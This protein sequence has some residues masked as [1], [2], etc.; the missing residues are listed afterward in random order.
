MKKSFLGDKPFEEAPELYRRAS[1]RHRLTRDA[2]PTLILHG[3]IDTP[4]P[5]EQSDRRKELGV[6]VVYDRPEGWPHTLAAIEIVKQLCGHFMYQF[7]AK[8]LPG[9]T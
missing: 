9:P 4:V 7:L 5:M 2:P 3:T 6:P 1:P 8:Y